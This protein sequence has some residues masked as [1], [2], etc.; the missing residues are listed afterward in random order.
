VRER[1][2]RATDQIEPIGVAQVH[3]GRPIQPHM[4]DVRGRGQQREVLD[5]ACGP[6]G[7]VA[8]DLFQHGDR[9]LAAA[10]AD[11]VRDDRPASR[12]VAQVR[13]QLVEAHQV[14]QVGHHPLGAGLHEPRV[15]EG[16]QVALQH[17]QLARHGAEQRAQ[18]VA[19]L[20]VA[21]PHVRR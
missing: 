11:R 9:T 17:G 3:G 20:R 13:R 7:D 15:V 14:G 2:E 18:R 5:R 16:G 8:G 19:G 4:V 10:V 6:A 1:V 12:R 21:Q